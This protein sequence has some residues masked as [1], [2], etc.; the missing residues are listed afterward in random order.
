MSDPVKKMIIDEL[1][2]KMKVKCDGYNMKGGASAVDYIA[3]QKKKTLTVDQRKA[4]VKMLNTFIRDTKKQQKGGGFIQDLFT[5]PK[6]R[7]FWRDFKTGFVKGF[8]GV[9]KIAEPVL[10][11]LSIVQPELA[12]VAMGVSAINKF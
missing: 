10:S 12:P 2:R 8:T 6:A 9:S 3:R 11:A 5:G 7:R 1:F 4:L